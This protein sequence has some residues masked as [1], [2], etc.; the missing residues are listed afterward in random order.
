MN[1]IH[2]FELEDQQWF[3]S[4]LR[5]YATDFL[6]FGAN[7]FDMYK[8]VIPVIEKGMKLSKSET[9]NDLASGGGGGW[10]KI[11]EHLKVKHPDVKVLLSDYYPNIKSFEFLKKSDP[12]INFRTESIDAKTIKFENKALQTMFL[13][14]HHFKPV[15]AKQILQNSVDNNN[16]MLIVESQDRSFQSLLAMFFSPI[17]LWLMT[18]MIKPFSFLRIIFTY[19]IPI[20]PIFVW[21]DGIISSLRTY[22]VDELKQMVLEVKNSESY[23]WEIN[24]VK[25]GPIKNIYL[26]AYPKI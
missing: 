23:E 2:I 14:F 1:R 12:A 11:L 25:S 17:S 15:Y 20:L 19:L 10:I 5:N 22:S 18:P 24:E 4:F 16:V 26:L 9:I 8:G 3:P 13:S 6:Q 7:R 21:W